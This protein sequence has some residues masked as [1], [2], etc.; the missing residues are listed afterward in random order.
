MNIAPTGSQV[1]QV[2]PAAAA[3][4]EAQE[5]RAVTQ[6][7]AAKGDRVAQR[8][9]AKEAAT[10]TEGSGEPTAASAADDKG[11]LTHVVA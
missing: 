2:S 9:L 4:Q 6:Q 1:P 11:Q 3:T 8:K 7:E 5:S 10:E